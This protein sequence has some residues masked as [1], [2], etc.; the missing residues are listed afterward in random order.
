M[1]MYLRII[2]C[3]VTFFLTQHICKAQIRTPEPSGDGD[4]GMDVDYEDEGE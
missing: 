2:L 1:K 4:E 3:L